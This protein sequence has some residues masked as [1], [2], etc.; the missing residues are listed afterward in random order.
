L[1]AQEAFGHAAGADG[2]KKNLQFKL[3]RED[4]RRKI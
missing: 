4:D 2:T 3:I 1:P